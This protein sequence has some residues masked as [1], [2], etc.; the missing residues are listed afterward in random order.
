MLFLASRKTYPPVLAVDWC[1]RDKYLRRL[2]WW[3]ERWYVVEGRSTVCNLW[4]TCAAGRAAAVHSCPSCY[5]HCAD[6]SRRVVHISS[7]PGAKRRRFIQRTPFNKQREAGVFCGEKIDEEQA[8]PVVM[9][10]GH[11][12]KAGRMSECSHAT[13]D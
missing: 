2:W 5:A 1:C 8:A 11:R 9:R 4:A 6:L 10:V 12:R 7:D 13:V 3:W